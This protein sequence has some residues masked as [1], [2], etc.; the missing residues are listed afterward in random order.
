MAIGTVTCLNF[1]IDHLQIAVVDSDNRQVTS[2]QSVQYEFEMLENDGKI[3]NPRRTGQFLQNIVEQYRLP[4]KFRIGLSLKY[5]DLKILNLPSMPPAELVRVITDEAVRESIFSFSSQNIAVASRIL[6]NEKTPTGNE[7]EILTATIPRDVIDSYITTFQLAGFKLMTIQPLLEGF[8]KSLL[9][10]SSVKDYAVVNLQKSEAELYIW[11]ESTICFWRVLPAG[12][13]NGKQLRSE[14][15]A[16]LEHYQ[17]RI[18]E[19]NKVQKIYVCGE[20]PEGELS[21]D[22]PIEFLFE[23]NNLGLIGIGLSELTNLNF[24]SEFDKNQRAVNPVF[25]MLIFLATVILFITSSSWFGWQ[26]WNKFENLHYL[27]KQ[28]MM[29]ENNLKSQEAATGSLQEEKRLLPASTPDYALLF[30]ELRESVPADMRFETMVITTEDKS[31]YLEGI[32]I[33]PQSL[34]RFLSRIAHDERLK[35]AFVEESKYLTDGSFNR[36]FFKIRIALEV[37]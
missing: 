28:Y 23:E 20:K 21:L 4:L 22:I 3:L 18:E 37:K 34:N 31:I 29:L 13:D 6:G 1:D 15:E 30:E 9:Q 32:C 33:N 24:I 10:R 12:A 17:R 5:L 25:K 11:T 36:Y 7:L 27:K 35:N 16:S 2:C 19:T 14:I 26:L 8:E